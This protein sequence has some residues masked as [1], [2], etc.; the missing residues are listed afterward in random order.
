M[1]MP[2]VAWLLPGLMASAPAAAAART[3]RFYFEV[4]GVQV[5]A[6]AAADLKE[7]A[8]G[9]LLAELKRQPVVVMELGAPRPRGAE[10]EKALKARGLTGYE[11]VLRVVKSKHSLQPPPAGKV[12]KMLMVEV[13]V[14]IDAQ[15]IPGGQ[16]AL[17]GEG[18]AQVGTEVSSVRDKEKQELL[19][20]ALA[21]AIKQAVAKSV[22]K[23]G[24]F[25][26]SKPPRRKKK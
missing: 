2:I 1:R 19:T 3:P 20:E 25:K 21:E 13:E 24:T 10:L 9:V 12:Y 11:L 23:L 5:P 17:A 16:M 7:R 6:G 26:A 14:A 4:R 22:S 8:R 18:T 15:K